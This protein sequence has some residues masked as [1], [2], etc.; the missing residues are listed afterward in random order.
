MLLLFSACGVALATY[1]AS[2]T[3]STLKKIVKLH[4]I[5]DL[6]QN[7]IISILS[8]QSDLYTVNTR[9]GKKV[10][11]MVTN[12]L[13]LGSSA[14][15][16]NNC[17]HKPAIAQDLQEIED[18]IIA[19]QN[20]L[21]YYITASA[22]RQRIERLKLDAAEIGNDLLHKTEK[23]SSQAAKKL[24]I[25]TTLA[26]QKLEQVKIILFSTIGITFF[27]GMLISIYL[28]RSVTGPITKLVTAIR[29]VASGD[30]DHTVNID[31]KTE[32]GELAGHFNTMS[33]TLKD[34]YESLVEE[35]IARHRVEEALRESEDRYA[36][37]ARGSNDGLWD[38]DLRQ[39]EIYYSPRWKSMLGFARDEIG[40]SLDEW[41]DRVDETDRAIVKA[42][43]A[44]HLNGETPHFECEYRIHNK[45]NSVLWMLAR[46]MA[47]CDNDG[48]AYRV[49]GSQTDITVRKINE[50]KMVHD[51]LH[52]HLTG[53]PNRSLFM[54]RLEHIIA[55]SKRDTNH[56][57]AVLFADL[58]RFK[59]INDCFGHDIGDKLLIE[60]GQ[61]LEVCLRP[62][63]TVAR[64]GGDEFAIILEEIVSTIDIE[65]I[66]QRILA[67]VA[68]PFHIDGHELFTSQSI[69]IAFKSE[70]YNSAEDLLRDADVAMYQAKAKGGGQ[71]VFFDLSMH[72]AIIARNQLETD[73]RSAVDHVE[74]FILH[75]QPIMNLQ[76]RSLSGFEAL[77]RWN[78][79]TQGLIS[80]NTFI[81]L[82]EETGL[83][84]PLSKWIIRQACR[85]LRIWHD[86]YKRSSP[87]N[88]SVNISS[89]MLLLEDFVE[90]VATC[91]H[92]EKIPAECLAIEITESVI[93]E[94]TNTAQKT[95]IALQDMG[96]N[97]HIDDFG[98]GYSFL[99][100]L[101]NFPVN[102]LKIDRS[103]ISKISA[104]GGN[105]DIVKTI[106]TLA[107]N[108]NLEV[109]AEGVEHEHQLSAIV[110]LDCA[111]GQGFFFSKGLAA[112][113]IPCWIAS[114]NI[115]T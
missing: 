13:D 33:S 19:Y 72:S 64:F 21:S 61:R 73:L 12:V 76:D 37:A 79:P 44:E 78:H 114:K 42:K 107:H 10:D 58:D 15:Y 110:S 51:A 22:N 70:Q 62:G 54:D 18:L 34:N 38:L 71:F 59:I 91:L 68:I 83:I 49:A 52:D 26:L 2:N 113:D 24:D 20:S 48:K 74:D 69:G 35:V 93:I 46:G 23:M 29:A 45:D 105:L 87:L 92:E 25:T 84:I 80:P 115:K 89:K 3:T 17:H 9:F 109:I 4:Q 6:R 30:F 16:C 55:L 1:F 14:T 112:D 111:Y 103:F 88:M 95:L 40:S 99:S 81:P 75:Y 32:F 50:E 90:T 98:T 47:V 27:L 36:L 56:G 41:L 94:H 67:E 28:T 104:T 66:V 77:I 82:A 31:D 11:I 108:L 8:V 63:D 100:Y 86:I 39:D 102:A 7:L 101:H 43:L 53:L 65:D 106:I 57:Y 85:Q 96:I 97:I 60:L 5:E